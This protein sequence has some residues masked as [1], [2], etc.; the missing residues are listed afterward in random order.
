MGYLRAD[1]RAAIRNEIWI[2]PTVSCVNTTV[3]IIA[4]QARALYGDKCDGIFL[5]ILTMRAAPQL[6]D[7]FDTTRSYC[8]PS[9]ITQMPAVYC[10]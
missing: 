6:G 5:R 9:S 2:I 7:D 10:W 8:P 4:E 1:G 3:N